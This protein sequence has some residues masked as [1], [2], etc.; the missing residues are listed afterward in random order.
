LN[1]DPI[2]ERGF[3]LNGKLNLDEDGE[4]G[5]VVSARVENKYMVVLNDSINRSDYLGLDECWAGDC[6]AGPG[7]LNACRDYANGW[8]EAGHLVYE[9]G[10]SSGNDYRVF[11]SDARFTRLMKSDGCLQ[12][13]REFW[14]NKNQG[15][16]CCDT[17]LPMTG[18]A[19]KFGILELIGAGLNPAQQFVG[20]YSVDIIPKSNGTIRVYIRNTTSF[21][22]LMYGVAPDWERNWFG[23]PCGNMR[24]LFTW[25]ELCEDALGQ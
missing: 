1:R 12:K 3:I 8:I 7:F 5:E 13:A 23:V 16:T 2:G 4:D 25:T 14:R 15:K 18:Y 9:W 20:S 10:V 21:K 6:S 24:Q 22:S 11:G 17:L 19:C